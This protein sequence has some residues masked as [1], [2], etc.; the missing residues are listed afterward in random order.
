MGECGGQVEA[1]AAEELEAMSR[2]PQ[3]KG[4]GE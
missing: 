2:P 4:L 3:M 1:P